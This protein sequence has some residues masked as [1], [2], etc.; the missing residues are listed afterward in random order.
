LTVRDSSLSACT[1]SIV[2]AE[3]GHLQLAYDY[4]GEAAF[5]D[6]DD[7]SHNTK[8]GLHMAS[9]AGSWLAV[10]CGFGG[11][12]D[13]GGRLTF[14]PRIPEQMVRLRFNLQWHG[15]HLQVEVTPGSATYTCIDGNPI[16]L[17]HHG[18]HVQA[19]KN[20]PVTR[21]I[22]PLEDRPNPGQPK[23]RAPEH[24]GE[25]PDSTTRTGR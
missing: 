6:L 10:V 7:L 4:L 17:T 18:E 22:P 20:S 9:L 8:D 19:I 21:P 3:T 13:H 25:P 24:R 11:M 12:R 16:T 5:M 14:K 15:G 23:G 1:Q 2:A